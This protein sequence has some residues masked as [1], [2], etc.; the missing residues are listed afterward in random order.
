MQ[1]I[2]LLPPP[3][4]KLNRIALDKLKRISGLILNI[5]PDN[6]KSGPAVSHAGASLTAEGVSNFPH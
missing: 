4:N 2:K 1:K 6:L 3:I 5:N